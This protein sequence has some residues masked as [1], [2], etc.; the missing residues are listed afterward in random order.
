MYYNITMKYIAVVLSILLFF[1]ASLLAANAVELNTALLAQL[2]ELV[3]IGPA[4]GQRIIDGRPYASVDDLAKVKGIGEKTLQ[5]IK[6]QGLAY[7]AQAEAGKSE[8]LNPKPE[9]NSNTEIQITKTYPSGIVINEILPSPDGPD[10]TNE[11][12]ELYNSTDSQITIAGWRLQDA[13]GTK[14]GYLFKQNSAIGAGQ[15]MALLRTETKI[16]LNDQETI[17]LVF[18]DGKIADTVSYSAAPTKKSY[19]KTATGWNW[20]SAPTPGAKNTIA[21]ATKALPKTKKTDNKTDIA[22]AKTTGPINPNL[23]TADLKDSTSNPWLLFMIAG[24]LTII[25][26]ATFFIIKLFINRKTHVRP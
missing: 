5:K 16:L 22:L 13:Q 1:P 26:G 9:T 3:G 6:D 10:E 14:G 12:I 17:S 21:V 24:A 23:F 20:S 11:F 25:F 15:Y 4:I 19:S 7:V 2:D 8:T 18:P